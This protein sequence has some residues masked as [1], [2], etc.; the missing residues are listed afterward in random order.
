MKQWIN[1]FLNIILWIISVILWV[2]GFPYLC[3][4]LLGLHFVEL[5]VVGWRTGRT[6]GVPPLVSVIMCMIYG[7]NWWLPLR[8]K[9]KEDTLTDVDFYEGV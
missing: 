8:K 3:W 6:F 1:Y 7:Y 9:I 2:T 5:V 4:F